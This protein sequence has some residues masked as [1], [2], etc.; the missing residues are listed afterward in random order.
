M[1]SQIFGF[2]CLGLDKKLSIFSVIYEPFPNGGI[3][4]MGAYGGTAE[5]SKSYFGEPVCETIVAGDIN[6]DC[7]VN[8]KDFAL[9]AFHWLEDNNP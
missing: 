3:I 7:K 6:G 8:F 9:M 2:Q 5:A 1:R 4:N